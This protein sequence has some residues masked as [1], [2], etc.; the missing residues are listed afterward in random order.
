MKK[1]SFTTMAV[2]FLLLCTNGIQAQ[3]KL[4][5][6]EL[7]KQFTGTWKGE[8]GKDT[9]FIWIGESIGNGIE[10]NVKTMTKGKII[11]K[12]K[13]IVAYDAKSDK[14]IETEIIDG[15]DALI[16]AWWFTSKNVSISIPFQD[17]SNPENA[18]FKNKFEI[19]SPDI[20]TQTVMVNNNPIQTVTFTR[21]K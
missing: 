6:V 21:E 13:M 16:Y 2:V 19:K 10:A 17:F 1:I 4:N 15:S 12:G 14:F 18:S 8:V 3:T 5:Q 20:V 11:S 9:T 7:M